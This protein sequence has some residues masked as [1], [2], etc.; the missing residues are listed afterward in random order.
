MRFLHT[1]DWQL[2]LKLA[3]IPGDRGAEARLLRFVAVGR[4][5]EL[6]HAHAVDGV[7]VCGDVFDDNAVG[8]EVLQRAREALAG[9][10]PLPV[11][12]LPGNHDWAD[13]RGALARLDAGGHVRVCAAREP[14]P[15][16]DGT[17][18]PCP[19]ARR[20]ERD[21]P[22]AWLPAAPDDGRPA[23][24]MAHGGIIDFAALA[25]DGADAAAADPETPNLIDAGAVLERGYDYL[26][27]GDWHGALAAGPRVR[28]PGTPEPTRLKER[29]PGRA[30]L[31]EIPARGAEP[32]VE[33]LPVAATS[34]TR[35]R[36][37]LDGGDAVAALA[38]ELAALE[39]PSRTVLG[40][41]LEGSLPLAA[42]T[43]LEEVLAAW[44]ERLLHLRVDSARLA[45]AP[46]TAD[47]EALRADPLLARIVDRLL[48]G[49]EEDLPALHLL[50]RL[51]PAVGEDRACT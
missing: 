34:W 44:S 28:Y 38:A 11:L 10:A 42:Q 23:V 37:A 43:R 7:L 19:L 25:R 41:E 29:D 17:V 20:H 32:A 12:L 21:D 9:F 30:L 33:A 5:V 45:V 15:L 49:G 39:R 13:P 24:V 50:H 3:F 16:G 36:R 47:L 40:L 8:Q 51:L 4:L 26:A 2:G 35:W 14:L 31:V 22:T 6:A 48:A 46:S 18:W 27:L 1:A